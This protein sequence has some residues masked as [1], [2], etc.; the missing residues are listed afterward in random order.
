[1]TID[2]S[3]G[4]TPGTS[5]R[6][7]RLTLLAAAAALP[8]FWPGLADLVA[9]WSRPEFRP[10]AA[11]PFLAV[12]L[13]VVGPVRT[14]T[15]GRRRAGVAL[16]LAALPLAL[17][18]N[19][20]QITD[21]AFYALLG[22]VAGL[23]MIHGVRP[24]AWLLLLALAIPPPR[25]LYLRLQ[26]RLDRLDAEL[27]ERVLR[28]ADLPPPLPEGA[29]AAIQLG[30]LL[31][32]VAFA[33]FL[34]TLRPALRPWTLAPVLAAAPIAI[35]LDVLRLTVGAMLAR[36]AGPG[37]A[38]VFLGAS[39]G[40]LPALT[41]LALVALI[42]LALPANGRRP[43]PVGPDTPPAAPAPFVVAVALATALASTVWL[44]VP[45]RHAPVTV[46]RRAFA[47]FPPELQGWSGSGVA[48]DARVARVLEADDYISAAYYRPDEPAPVEFF[49]AYY[50]SQARGMS[51]HSPEICLPSDG[52][53][54][55]TLTRE[56]VPLAEDAGMVRVNRA[57]IE[58]G[59]RTA[60]AYYWFEGRGRRTANEFAA[61]LL[62]RLDGLTTGRTDGAL[63]RVVTPVL[64]GEGEAT[65][66]ARLR[67]LMAATV[68][69]LAGFIPE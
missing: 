17:A 21:L 8:L 38:E 58:R 16:A 9:E 11:L 45:A 68:P 39:S 19:L 49:A 13:L 41:A 2:A 22:W 37:A 29:E 42:A 26:P 66:D 24:W 12:W 36:R 40:W 30:H 34:V 64:P 56:A 5:S 52:W 20:L 50:A 31:P 65:A 23:A 14:A 18:G 15:A 61:R 46:E 27:T 60:L 67:R 35:G 4:T 7:L 57:L 53:T 48:L 33:V 51:I 28:A 10:M 55:R 54:I 43:A 47:G 63:V 44:A 6:D 3:P 1:M 69:R 59:P 32:I 62:L 25:F